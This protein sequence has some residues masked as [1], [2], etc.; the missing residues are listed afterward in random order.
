MN[1][2]ATRLPERPSPT[3]ILVWAA[4]LLAS[5][6]LMLYNLPKFQVGAHYDDAA[7]ITLARSFLH[8]DGYGLI[9]YPGDPRVANYPFG[10]PL[11]L[12]ILATLFPEELVVYKTISVLATLANASLIFWGWRLLSRKLPYTW[13]LGISLLYLFS[14]VTIDLSGRVMAEPIF[15][16]FY[17]FAMLVVAK[18]TGQLSQDPGASDVLRLH[19]ESLDKPKSDRS[20]ARWFWPVGLGMLLAMI[21]FTRTIGISIL[22]GIF[23]YLFIDLI[24]Q[25]KGLPRSA[26]L[27]WLIRSGFS[28]STRIALGAV[29]LVFLVIQFTSVDWPDLIPTKYLTDRQAAMIIGLTGAWSENGIE[30]DLPQDEPGE[31]DNATPAVLPTAEV[32]A[33]PGS[34]ASNLAQKR[35]LQGLFQDYVIHGAQQHFGKSLRTAVFPFAGTQGEEN[36]A[37][38]IGLPFLPTLVGYIF[39][40]LIVIGYVRWIRMENLTVFN[41]SSLVYFFSLFAWVWNEPRFLNPIA[42]QL[43]VGF[44]LGIEAIL[45]ILSRWSRALAGYTQ[46]GLAIFGVLILA[47]S[48]FKSITL[49]D[50]RLHIGVLEQRTIWLRENTA[51]ES[52]V[53]S[54]YPV[55]D[56]LYGA[57]VTASLPRELA[58]AAELDRLLEDKQISFLLVAP[59]IRWMLPAYQPAYSERMQ[60]ALPII[61]TLTAQSRLE[62]VFE[63]PDELIVVYQV[64]P[65]S[66]AALPAP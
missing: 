16:T 2:N 1:T 55:I 49:A 9:N 20:R 17:L 52:I 18:I 37:N 11:L 43:L 38:R 7:Y 8:E 63:I 56:Y 54:E 12:S 48:I 35:G 23:L 62:R 64:K 34:S 61:N 15:L 51:P 46:T 32:E 60:A 66:S 26:R 29:V 50:S 57:R 10:Y 47:L 6:G 14:P 25:G 21:I 53:L 19:S 31:S 59:E 28:L 33:T 4:A 40:I 22:A 41:L 44:F 58:S 36:F 45:L 5:L 24:Q 42:P 13:G 27:S 3:L 30:T 65:L 39:S